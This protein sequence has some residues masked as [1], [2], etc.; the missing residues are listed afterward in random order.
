MI[1]RHSSATME[2]KESSNLPKN[3]KNMVE[4]II[5]GTSSTS[6]LKRRLSSAALSVP[7]TFLNESQS[8]HPSP[9]SPLSPTSQISHFLPNPIKNPEQR[10]YTAYTIHVRKKGLQRSWS[11]QR[12]Y[13]E[14]HTLHK[15]LQQVQQNLVLSTRRSLAF[16]FQLEQNDVTVPTLPPK[17]F[18]NNMK[19]E[20]VKKRL[21]GLQQFLDGLCSQQL[22][23]QTDAVKEF[24][25]LNKYEVS[26]FY[27][28]PDELFSSVFKFLTMKD[29][30]PTL[31]HVCK[32][33]KDILYNSFQNMNV[34]HIKEYVF[35]NTTAINVDVIPDL[36]QFVTLFKRLRNVTLSKIRE[37]TDEDLDVIVKNCKFLE[38]ISLIS[39]GRLQQPL[40]SLRC[41]ETTRVSEKPPALKSVTINYC[42]KVSTIRFIDVDFLSGL[43]NLNLIGT[44]LDDQQLSTIPIADFTG[45]TILSLSEMKNLKEPIIE[46]KSLNIL[47]MRHC[48]NLTSPIIKCINLIELDLGR[49][50]IS[51]NTFKM[52][53]VDMASAKNLEKL[54]LDMC[55]MLVEPDLSQQG[56]NLS[57]LQHINLAACDNLERLRVGGERDLTLKVTLCQK[58]TRENIH[59]SGNVLVII[60]EII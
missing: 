15:T 30:F 49:T 7:S 27:K 10:D 24:L 23:V 1:R 59:L 16:D 32:W 34:S 46:S 41:F 55:S 39:C 25:T 45:L 21:V 4:A 26:P 22:L 17:I 60:N 6:I 35:F 12:R 57:K 56:N 5:V 40:L 44:R 29:L 14:F 33:W 2:Q 9:Q 18:F 37:L 51:E 19:Q 47:K 42:F 3:K 53:V 31:L 52:G 13:R 28:L 38:N 11:V 50:M 36:L 20:N 58:L 48:E 54:N 8:Y 43:V